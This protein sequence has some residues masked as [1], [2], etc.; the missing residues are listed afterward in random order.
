MKF[1]EALNDFLDHRAT[2]PDEV[3]RYSGEEWYREYRRLAQQLDELVER[4]P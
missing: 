1:S 4:K 3:D 2:K